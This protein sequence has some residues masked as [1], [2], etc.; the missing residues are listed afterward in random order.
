V[1]EDPVRGDRNNP[2]QL[3]LDQ[4]KIFKLQNL[5]TLSEQITEDFLLFPTDRSAK[6]S[7]K[8]TTK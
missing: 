8:A 4:E 6:E 2:L 5:F 1:F 7:S 3:E